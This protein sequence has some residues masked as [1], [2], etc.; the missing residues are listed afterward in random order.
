MKHFLDLGTHKFEG[1]SEFCN[2]LPIDHSW[3]VQCYEA[4][5]LVYKKALKSVPRFENKFHTFDFFNYA[6]LDKNGTTIFHCHKGV[7]TDSSKKKFVSEVTTGSN[8]LENTPQCDVANGHVFSFVDLEVKC[9]DINDIVSDICKIDR[10]AEIYIKCDIEGSE[11]VVLPRL[12]ESQYIKNVKQLHVEWHERFWYPNGMAEKIK[13]KENCLKRFSD[14][15]IDCFP[16]PAHPAW[17]T[18]DIPV[19]RPHQR[20]V[21]RVLGLVDRIR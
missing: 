11:F 6:V 15:R 21:R 8:A 5:P 2:R 16:L 20:L 3:A 17:A 18:V 19:L 1:L 7:W 13:E 12:L 4:N 14:L 10:A 9:I